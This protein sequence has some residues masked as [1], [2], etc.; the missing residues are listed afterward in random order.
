MTNFHFIS[1]STIK[2]A[3]IKNHTNPRLELTPWDL[4]FLPSNYIQ[5]G[6]LYSKQESFSHKHFI[7]HLEVTLSR[8]LDIF[9]PLAGRLAKTENEDH[10]TSFFVDCN[11][12]GALFIHAS[13]IDDI[14]VASILDPINIPD[15]IVYSFFPM[16]GVSNYQGVSQPLLAVQVTELLDGLF[17]AISMN[18]AVADGTS[19]WHF[20]N[21]W[22]EISNKL[23]QPS[24]SFSNDCLNKII[25]LPLHIPY[26]PNIPTATTNSPPLQQRMFHFSKES[27]ANLKA[28]ANAE[29]HTNKI[30]SFQALL[31][32]LWVSIT[33]NRH[34]LISD[35][36]TEVSYR[37]VVGMRRRM[38][39][40]LPENYF[41]NALLGVLFKSTVGEVLKRG[42]GDI[43][44]EMNLMIGS[45]RGEEARS[46]LEEWSKSPEFV[47]LGRLK[48]NILGISG[49]PRFDVYGNEFGWG[50]PIAVRS[51][52][53]NKFDGMLTV[54]PG[55]EQG[56]VDFEVCLLP[57]TL[58]A[59]ANDGE[60]METVYRQ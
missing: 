26:F 22:S 57:Q 25:N 44:L 30:S 13:A 28:K 10:T 24:P 32:H 7:K 52:P 8:T 9:Y 12:Y 48:G 37:V 19:F 60:F 11:H 56:S 46:F 39:P 27:I 55:V 16:N 18:H 20:F 15:D 4:R 59:M 50:K 33:R 45:Q 2:P 42:F 38:D 51:G 35:N 21:V 17:I 6:L 53:G 43:G 58:Q 1:T 36:D 34:N 14:T 29:A 54:Y 49:S 41:G 23:S 3:T 40:P 5:K 47:E 31:A